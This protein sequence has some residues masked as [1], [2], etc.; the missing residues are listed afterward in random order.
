MVVEEEGVVFGFWLFDVVEEWLVE[1]M[2][3]FDWMF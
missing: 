1:V 3:F 2:G